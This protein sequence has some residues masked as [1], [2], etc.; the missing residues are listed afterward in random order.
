MARNHSTVMMPQT[1]AVVPRD[2][3]DSAQPFSLGDILS[4][5]QRM[6]RIMDA[7]ESKFDPEVILGIRP[8]TEPVSEEERERV[9]AELRRKVDSID[10]VLDEFRDYAKRTYERAETISKRAA[11]ADRR[12]ERL[13]R[14]VLNVM[15]AF[16]FERL[17]GE[18]RFVEIRHA[19]NP[20]LVVTR[21][22]TPEDMIAMPEYVLE[23]PISYTWNNKALKTALKGGAEVSFASLVYKP[24]LHF[25][26]RDKP[27][28]KEKTKSKRERMS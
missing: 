14:Y 26:D 7:D 22:P 5:M 23:V 16:G 4:E 10:Y 9:L 3:E 1:L 24:R 20:A 28:I 13:D 18:E 8:P 19:S 25:D 21:D 27:A 11:A 12:A 15:Q 2:A 17:P 6:E